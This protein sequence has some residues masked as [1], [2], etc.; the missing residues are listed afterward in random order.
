[1]ARSS[2]PHRKEARQLSADARQHE[3]DNR[4]TK[5]QLALLDTRRGNSA[6]ERKRLEKLLEKE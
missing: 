1:M 4:S 2:Q 6:K 3:R 5:E